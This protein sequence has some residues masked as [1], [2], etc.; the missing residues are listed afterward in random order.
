MYSIIIDTRE[1]DLITLIPSLISQYKYSIQYKVETLLIGDIEIRDE[2]NRIKAIFERKTLSDLASS[3]VDGRYKEQSLRLKETCT[4]LP[5]HYKYYIVE[6][7]ISKYSSTRRK[8]SIP[9]TTLYGALTSL[10]FYKGFSVIR[11]I[12]LYETGDYIVH[13]T[14]K[15]YRMWLK[16][17]TCN[18]FNDCNEPISKPG[19]E[20]SSILKKD[21]HKNITPEN[22]NIVFLSQIPYVSYTIAK[23][24]VKHYTSLYNLTDSLIERPDCLNTLRVNGRRLSK[25]VIHNIKTYLGCDVPPNKVMDISTCD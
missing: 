16:D 6:G 17:K 15:L 22:I 19:V 21:K 2:R 9:A 7:D 12:H 24:L 1:T 23:E 13:F 8:P 20:Y 5:D 18:D 14:N 25:S 10:S 11:T 4:E 3:I